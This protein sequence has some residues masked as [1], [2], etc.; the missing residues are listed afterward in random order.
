[1]DGICWDAQEEQAIRINAGKHRQVRNVVFFLVFFFFSSLCTSNLLRVLQRN[2]S[3]DV[4]EGTGTARPRPC[5]GVRY[6]QRV[7]F[8][9]L[10]REVESVVKFFYLIS[11]FQL[12]QT[13][14]ASLQRSCCLQDHRQTTF[15]S[16]PYS[17]CALH[18]SGPD[19][20]L[21]VLLEH[22]QGWL[23]RQGLGSQT[24]FSFFLFF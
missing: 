5:T 22:P 3:R 9:I 10:K 17:R 18:P 24:F 15:L 1:M 19:F 8:S 21:R 23:E 12:V 13:A 20:Q 7:L 2:A 11:A 14:P 16:C 4:K 6:A